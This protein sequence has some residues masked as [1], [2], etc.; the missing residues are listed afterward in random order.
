MESAA[1]K[2]T[3]EKGG[4]PKIK[5]W[6]YRG[7]N[8][9]ALT[10]RDVEKGGGVSETIRDDS[11]T[12]REIMEKFT[13]HGTPIMEGKEKA[14]YQGD[15]VSHDS[16][17]LSKIPNMDLVDYDELLSDVKARQHAA[18]AKIKEYNERIALENSEK[19]R[20][21]EE[22]EAKKEGAKGEVQRSQ[23]YPTKKATYDQS[24]AD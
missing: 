9:F 17:D 20:L 24:E 15:E 18:A 8:Q 23:K 16:A 2:L 7:Y 11:Y 21:A 6:N 3:V 4:A 12:I 14:L 19:V 22:E 5:R 13:I 1:K 10:M